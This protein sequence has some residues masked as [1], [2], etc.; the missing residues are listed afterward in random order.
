MNFEIIDNCYQITALL[1]CMLI[2]ACLGIRKKNR[3]YIM[4]AFGYGCFMMGTLFFVLHLTILG[5]VPQ[6]FYTCE[7]SWLAAYL[8]FLSLLLLRAEYRTL[9]FSIGALIPA[10]LTAAAILR[11][12]IFGPA[13]LPCAA[14]AATLGTIVYFAGGRILFDRKNGRWPSLLDH[15]FLM[16]VLLQVGIYIISM[17]MSDFVHFNLYFAVDMLLSV[18]L[19]A[20]LPLLHREVCHDLH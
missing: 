19:A 17:F 4:L 13:L 20:L 6:I 5:Y 3:E 10:L 7:I 16:C 1:I 9:P 14:C 2:S 15:C 11:F 18:M 8:F 12:Q